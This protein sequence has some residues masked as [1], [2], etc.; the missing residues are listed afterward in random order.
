MFKCKGV[1]LRHT[2]ETF[3]NILYLFLHTCIVC[4]VLIVAHTFVDSILLR[5]RFIL[6]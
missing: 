4:G 2:L 5:P 1:I 6:I 3:I